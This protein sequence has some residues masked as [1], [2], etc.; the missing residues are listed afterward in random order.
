T[1]ATRTIDFLYRVIR[2]RTTAAWSV[3]AGS[4]AVRRLVLAGMP[5]STRVEVVCRGGG[6][7]FARRAFAARPS[8]CVR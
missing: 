7:P 4:T 5:G 2:P 3:G 8:A 1:S 6:C